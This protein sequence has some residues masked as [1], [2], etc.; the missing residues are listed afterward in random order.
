[1]I[2]PDLKFLFHSDHVDLSTARI[3]LLPDGIAGKRIFS[4]KYPIEVG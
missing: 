3:S 4:K 2:S 1:V